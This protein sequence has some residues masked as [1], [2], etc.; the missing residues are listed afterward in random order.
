MYEHAYVGRTGDGKRPWC[1]L[2]G[3]ADFRRGDICAA[4]GTDEMGRSGY[5][6]VQAHGG[7]GGPH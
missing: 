4:Q 6:R 3:L 5:R 1:E 7:G 2:R